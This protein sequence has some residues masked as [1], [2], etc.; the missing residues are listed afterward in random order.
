MTNP[1][2][3]SIVVGSYN[4]LAF[5]KAALESV[6]NNGMSFPYEIIVVDG[7]STDGSLE[8]LLK[9]KDVITIVQHNRGEFRGRKIER[10]SWGYFM[11]LGFKSAQGKFILMISDDSLLVPGAVENGVSVFEDAFNRGE[12]PGAIAFYWRNWPQ[13]KKYKVGFTLGDKMFVNHGMYLR[14]AVEKVGWADEDHYS[15]Y[16]SDGDLCLKLWRDGYQVLDSPHSFVEHYNHANRTVRQQNQTSQQEDW[17]VYLDRWTNIFFDPEKNN[18]GKRV[19]LDYEDV[20]RTVDAFP[21]ASRRMLSIC[22]RLKKLKTNPAIPQLLRDIGGWIYRF[23]SCE[24]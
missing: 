14:A 5:L 16:H 21:A 10:R 11:N 3:V 15:F 7:G 19:Y 24:K 1:P 6:R 13:E 22:M 18:F 2:L 8:Y 12:N 9:Q 17:R 20:T 4:R 23:L